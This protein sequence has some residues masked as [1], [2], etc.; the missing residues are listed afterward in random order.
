MFV[1]KRSDWDI[2][3]YKSHPRFFL[4]LLHDDEDDVYAHWFEW[5]CL[6]FK[7]N[8]TSFLHRLPRCRKTQS[9]R[10]VLQW[11]QS[12]KK[13]NGFRLQRFQ[14]PLV[15]MYK[16]G[17]GRC[18]ICSQRGQWNGERLRLCLSKINSLEKKLSTLKKN[19]I[20]YLNWMRGCTADL[21]KYS[22]L[23]DFAKKNENGV[24]WARSMSTRQLNIQNEC[25][26][27]LHISMTTFLNV[28]IYST[29]APRNS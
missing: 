12:E 27:L 13:A 25:I 8:K 5:Y 3:I 24:K 4:H 17:G 21:N 18:Q 11:H 10:N 29:T 2:Y 7:V 1:L 19:Q 9:C 20:N 15:L 22:S 14:R 26:C 23:M 16:L 6:Y 28:G